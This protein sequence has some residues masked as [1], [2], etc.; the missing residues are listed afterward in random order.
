MIV[1]LCWFTFNVNEWG[2]CLQGLLLLFSEPL[3]ALQ[4]LG[5]YPSSSRIPFPVLWLCWVI[6]ASIIELLLTDR[7]IVEH[8]DW[9]V[10]QLRYSRMGD[11]NKSYINT[12]RSITVT[13][14]KEDTHRI[15]T[16]ES[17]AIRCHVSLCS[18][19]C[20]SS[21]C[22]GNGPGDFFVFRSRA[23]AI[24]SRKSKEL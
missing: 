15:R 22:D 3:T 14:P 21:R 7:R 19:W 23:T 8:V 24:S 18:V 1:K 6:H 20:W 16:G 2:G 9:F 12:D 4:T 13:P 17:F 11:Q 5:Y 10:R